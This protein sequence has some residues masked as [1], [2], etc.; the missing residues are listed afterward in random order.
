[1][2]RSASDFRRSRL[3]TSP[4]PACLVLAIPSSHR[5]AVSLSLHLVP[6]A[7]DEFAD[8]SLPLSAVDRAGGG[9]AP[10]GAVRR[11]A[12]ADAGDGVDDD[13]VVAPFAAALVEVEVVVGTLVAAVPDAAVPADVS[14]G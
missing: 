3:G 12:D 8:Q 1:M 10:V 7:P 13:V 14:A 11:A 2:S 5:P 4:K 9:A 6:A